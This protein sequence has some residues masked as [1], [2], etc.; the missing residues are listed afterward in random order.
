MAEQKELRFFNEHY[1]RGIDWYKSHFE[2]APPAAMCG[3]ASPRYMSTPAALDRIRQHIPDV[4]LLA[5][6]RNPTARAWSG[7]L[8]LR[9]RK[10][11]TREFEEIV[12]HEVAVLDRE[13]RPTAETRMI[14]AS[15][16]AWNFRDMIERFDR[17]QISTTIFERM[18]EDPARTYR[19]FCSHLEIDESFEPDILGERI[20]PYVEFR[21][22]RV[23]SAARDIPNRFARRVVERFNTRR[24]PPVPTIPADMKRDLERFFAPHNAELEKLLGMRIPEWDPFDDDA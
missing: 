15:L 6:L 10:L 12:A 21:S 8:T 7:F 5:T 4:K 11:E 3:E 17:S 18:V 1:E 24:T 23:R 9:E 16:Y 13:G 22:V 20:N 19:Q 2:N 14:G